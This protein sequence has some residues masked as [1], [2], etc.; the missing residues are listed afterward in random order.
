MTEIK[1]GFPEPSFPDAT[2][3]GSLERMLGGVRPNLYGVRRHKAALVT[4]LGAAG[5]AAALANVA[6]WGTDWRAVQARL[7]RLRDHAYR[8]ATEFVELSPAQDIQAP[9]LAGVD[10]DLRPAMTVRT[11]SFWFCELTDA[12]VIS[13]SNLVLHDGRPLYDVEPGEWAEIP[14]QLDVDPAIIAHQGALLW[15]MEPPVTVMPLH[16]GR[17][18][19]LLGVHSYAYGHWICEFL[20]KLWT[21]LQRADAA[22]VTL[23]VDAQMPPQHLQALRLFVGEDWPVRVVPPGARVQVDRL[24]YC[25]MPS[26]FPVGPRPDIEY[27]DGLLSVDPVVYVRLLEQALARMMP[28]LTAP[29]TCLPRRIYLARRDNQHRRLINRADVEALF[30]AHGFAILDFWDVPFLEQLQYLRAAEVVAGPDGSAFMTTYFGR[31]GLRILTLTNPCLNDLQM[32]SLVCAARG[33]NY[34]VLPGEYAGREADY[35]EMTGYVT[36]LGTLARMLRRVL[37]G[38][39]QSFRGASPG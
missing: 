19:S 7:G 34:F 8:S 28:A 38:N 3:R 36:D 35:P 15:L 12:T 24:W 16:E 5:A 10:G 37:E 17:A 27:R 2:L 26:Y 6:G 20:P 30:A 9:A 39:A 13:K 14:L 33:Q 22:G 29:S 11:R 4:R 21:C 1:P 18:L 32:Y 25:S 23:L 31:R